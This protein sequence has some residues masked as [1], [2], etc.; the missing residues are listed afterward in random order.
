LSRLVLSIPMSLMLIQAPAGR[1]GPCLRF[2]TRTPR[3]FWARS[4]RNDTAKP[5]R[6]VSRAS[7]IHTVPARGGTG[8]ARDAECRRADPAM[9]IS[10]ESR[11]INNFSRALPQHCSF[12]GTVGFLVTRAIVWY[13]N[14]CPNRS[15]A[16]SVP[17]QTHFSAVPRKRNGVRSAAVRCA[18][19]EK[20]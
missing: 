15:V 10:T 4:T 13:R 1:T 2:H 17:R 9:S 18:G 5:M 14:G 12:L 11:K 8:F 6:R 20:N 19:P 7:S 16:I 3:V